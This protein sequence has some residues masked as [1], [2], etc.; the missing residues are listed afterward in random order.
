MKP[1]TLTL[2]SLALAA[3]LPATAQHREHGEHSTEQRRHNES[4]C[5]QRQVV[6]GPH[7]G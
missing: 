1:M 2:L 6:K 7:I 5:E 4:S 3:A